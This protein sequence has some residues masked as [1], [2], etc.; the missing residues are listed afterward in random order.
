M[1]IGLVDS[2]VGGLTVLREVRKV[3]PKTDIHYLADT[4]RFPY[5]TKTMEQVESYLLEGL[6]FLA[7]LGVEA[8]VVA[9]NTATAAGLEAA[10]RRYSFP[11]LGVIEAGAR[12]AVEATRCGRIGVVATTATV[13][14]GAYA[15]AIKGHLETA[16]IL[17]RSGQELVGAVEEGRTERSQVAKMVLDLLSP[18]VAAG[19]DVVVLGSTHLAVGKDVFR[20]FLGPEVTVVDPAEETATEVAGLGWGTGGS[21]KVLIFVTGDP[22]AFRHTASAVYPGNLPFVEKV[23]L[24]KGCG[25]V[26]ENNS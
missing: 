22:G 20:E 7:T 17:H 9:C 13:T 26:G 2:G 11:V 14:S 23:S 25:A 5:G 1:A 21:G 3:C 4:A 10:R 8:A 19:V 6:D 18:L 15:K 16:I 24:S 12:P